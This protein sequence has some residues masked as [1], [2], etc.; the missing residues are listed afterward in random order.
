MLST[1]RLSVGVVALLALLGVSIGL[2]SPAT[3]H[4]ALPSGFQETVVFD[5]LKDPTNVRFVSDGRIFVSEKSGLVKVFDNLNDATPTV[6]ADLSTD[7][8]NYWD[9]GLLGMAL[10]PQFTSGRPY[11]YLLYTYDAAPGGSAPRWG[12]PGVLDDPCPTPPGPTTAGCIATGRLV[13]L[14]ANG[15]TVVPNS[16]RV[17]IT[18]W[19][20]QYPSHSVGTLA[21]GADGALYAS[22]GDGA[23]FVFVDYGTDGTPVNPCGDPPGGVGVPLSPP[24]AEGGALRSQD[25]RTP[26]DPTGLDGAVIR[27]D[28]ETGSAMPDNPLAFSSDPNARRIIAHGF[29]NPFRFTFR[30]GTNDLWL[31]DVGWGDWEEINHLGPLSSVGNFGWPC[32]EGVGRQ[33]GYDSADLSMCE[34]LYASAGTVTSPYFTYAHSARVVPGETCPTGGSSIT[35]VSFYDGGNY[36]ASYNGA[37]FFAD[38]TRRCIWVMFPG[39]NGLPDPSRISTFQSDAAGP[40]DLQIGPG[41]DIFYSDLNSGTIR[42]FRFLSTNRPPQAVISANPTNGGAPLTVQF[43]G[44]GSTDPDGDPLTY[45]WDLDGDGTFFDSTFSQPSWTYP[46]GTF[47]ARLRVTDPSGATGTTSVVINAGN[48]APVVSVLTPSPTQ[49]WQVGE[50]I[51]FSGGAIDAE[52]GSLP[53]SRLR[54]ALD[55]HHCFDETSCHTHHLQDFVG[56]SGGSFAA[57]DH[58]YPSYLEL[59]LTATDTQGATDSTSVR[60]DPRTVDVSFASQPTGL[61]LTVGSSSAATPFTRRL[62]V[63]SVS[64]MSAPSPQ[65]LGSTTYQFGS[66][67][68]GGAAT[69]TIT[70][71]ASPATYTA[72]YTATG[73]SGLV[74]AYAFDEGSGTALGDRSGSGNNGTVSGATWSASGKYGAALSFDGVNDL[75]TVPDSNSLDLTNGMTLEAWVNPTV[76]GDWKTVMLKEQP[77]QLVYSLYGSNAANRPSGHVFVGADRELDGTAAVAVNTWTHLATTYDGATQRF[78]VNGTQVATRAQTGS[79]PASTGALR[80]GGNNVWSEWFGGRIDEVRIYRRAL[81]AAEIQTD[82]ATP[83]GTAPPPDTQAPT[84]PTGLTAQ[85]GVSSVTLGWTASTDN[86]GVNH[87]DVHRSTTVNFTPSA[88]NRI[89]QPATNAYTDSPAA[90][91]YFYKVIAYDAAGN[92]SGASNEATASVGD[93]QAPTAPANLQATGGLTT[94]ALT[95]TA[96]TDN[97]N[98][99]HYDVHRSTMAGFTPSAA[100]RIAQ[101]ATNAYTDSPAAGTYFYKVIAYDAAG[102][103]SAASNQASATVGDT[104]APTAPGNLNA[105]GALGQA[106]LSWT[107]ST[108]NV[109]VHHY[110]LHRSTVAGFLPSVANRVAVITAPAT[111]YL[112]AGLAAGVYFYKL[113]AYDAAGNGSAPSNEASAT[114]TADTT[115]PT[116]AITAPTQAATVSA[117]VSVTANASDN[118]GVSGVQF[119]LDGQNL[120][121]EDT[122]TPYSVSW[123]TTT[124]T[125]A[126]HQLTAD[127]RDAAGN[128]GLSVVVN[129][130]VNNTTPPVTGL[131][132]A[133]ALDE[134]SGTAVGD[135]S[136]TGNNGTIS[137]ATWSA[138]GKNGAALSFDGVNDLV[139]VPDSNSLDLTNGMTLEAWVNPTI[140]GDWKTV[141]L[142]E[143][144]GQLV[145]A[146]YGSNAA[147]RPSGHVFVGADRELNGTA[148]VAVNTWTHLATTYDGTT[149]RMFVNGTQVAT[150]AQTGSMPASTGALRIGGNNVWTEWFAGRI[151]DVRIYRRA[152][153][154]A[155]IQAD[156]NRPVS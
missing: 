102:N 44:T 87:Y 154:A 105:A 46:A 151:D 75:A 41:G 133:Y 49:L 11:I 96:S 6:F 5:G 61:Q 120:G 56:V 17:L 71:P 125:N 55:L 9:R 18:D 14:T 57:P 128:H 108:D 62:I 24:S 67:S 26:S 104:Q 141:M 117:T 29:R 132:A 7:V 137:G 147:N 142:K 143:Q 85:G 90:G 79:M 116:V 2:L 36:P 144:P 86:V 60:L 84:A 30:P 72:T 98:V 45:A 155:E 135:R 121:T 32:Y 42:R 51:N 118:V 28:P 114:V 23:S 93:T 22:G 113:V 92:A 115:A 21:F 13:R 152:L 53:A 38:Y 34:N 48:T 138:S 20:Q 136:G 66:W 10:D 134:G 47:T 19:C 68:D 119:K 150:R 4:A 156:M 82:M 80:I 58:E 8:Y 129:V 97:V 99:H 64:S 122:S 112:D 100:N 81:T 106:T 37:L 130:T 88:A 73:Q 103:A 91:T 127:A 146:L 78:F 83:L 145:Y 94:A 1:S 124:A 111:G 63:G 107:A 59:T 52:E 16:Q 74:A 77:G 40:V 12:T 140:T 54:W 101:P 3:A 65:T 70:A 123:D 50:T 39:T 153:T 76:T 43:D 149:Q 110:D 95:W 25:L 33:S 126:A 15:N 69:H 109:G 27:I 139:T 31:G 89:A 131:V 148:A 35:G